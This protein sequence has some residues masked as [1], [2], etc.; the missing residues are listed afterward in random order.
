MFL[1]DEPTSEQDD[2]GAERIKNYLTALK[3]N[4]SI[5]IIATNDER[6]KDIFNKHIV[7][8]NQS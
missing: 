6:I 1:L 5:M 4:T 8:G 2:D 3:N 7:L